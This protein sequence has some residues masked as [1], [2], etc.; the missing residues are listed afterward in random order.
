MK[1]QYDHEKAAKITNMLT[2]EKQQ[3][4]ATILQLLYKVVVN[5]VTWKDADL[6]SI[7]STHEDGCFLIENT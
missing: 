6:Y 1:K 2:T 7:T 3:T 4:A 5:Y